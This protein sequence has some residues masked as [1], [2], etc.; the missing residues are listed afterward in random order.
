MEPL[1]LPPP[2]FVAHDALYAKRLVEAV[3]LL[4]RLRFRRDERSRVHCVRHQEGVYPRQPRLTT[5]TV[6]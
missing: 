3:T 6:V 5:P 1:K 2:A 4:W